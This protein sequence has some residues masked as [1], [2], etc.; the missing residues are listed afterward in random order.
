[1]N[2]TDLLQGN[3]QPLQGGAPPI[4][5][6]A[7]P[8]N[9]ASTLTP[10]TSVQV[11]APYAPTPAQ[12]A[13]QPVPQVGTGIS[14]KPQAPAT[15]VQLNS[16]FSPYIATRPSPSNPNVLEYYN[17]Q[18]GQGFSTPQDLFNFASTLGA[19][20]I[21]SFDQL[22]APVQGAQ[23]TSY[24]GP[25]Q[26]ANSQQALA[27]AAG[28]AG[29][30]PSDFQQLAQGSSILTPDQIQQI[31]AG[32]GITPSTISSVFAPP[33]Q[34]TVDFYNQAYTNAGLDQIKQQYD[35]LTQQIS[36]AQSDYNT[37]L[38]TLNENPFLS[39][40]SLTQRQGELNQQAQ[41]QI[42]NLQQQ[43][44]SLQSLYQTGLQQVAGL[45][46]NYTTDFQNIQ[47]QNAT[48][49]NFLMQQAEALA[50]AQQ[51]ANVQ[52]IYRY[53]PDYLTAAQKAQQ[54]FGSAQYGYFKYDPTTKSFTQVSGPAP[55]FQ[56]NPLDGT[57]FNTATGQGPSA[58]NGGLSTAFGSPP[59]TTGSGANLP[60]SNNNPGDL[61]N[62]STG[63]FMVYST[64]QQGWDALVSDIQA[65]ISGNN[66]HGLTPNSTLQDFANVYDPASANSSNNPAKYAQDLA[67][68]L[69]VPVTTPIGTLSNRVQ[70]FA[71]AI[72]N[73]EGYFTGST[74]PGTTGNTLIQQAAQALVDGN[75][76]PS[77]YSK[78]GATY[79]TI[80]NAANQLSMAQ[81][82]VPF[83][84]QQAETNFSNREAVRPILNNE[85]SAET[86]LDT[87]LQKSA[88]FSRSDSPTANN[89]LIETG[90]HIT[91]SPA[92][93]DYL[94]AVQDAQ[95]EIAKVLSGTGTPTDE[96][97]SE[98]ANMLNPNLGHNALVSQINTIRSLMQQKIAAY[99]NNSLGVTTASPSQQ[100]LSV[101]SSPVN[102]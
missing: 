7:N 27:Q 86:H 79:Q 29:L 50:T 36:K 41:A 99:T 35:D 81:K 67:N 49:L 31:W 63:Q 84:A 90:K 46:Q 4:Q 20:P 66:A 28:N 72:A 43:Q 11:P 33:A 83:D 37:A 42:S 5:G 45:T 56:S 73:N 40:T 58:S 64:P 89:L 34:S 24:S 48:K 61:T 53:L 21:N 10:T 51:S 101:S 96:A 2:E 32:L 68:Q 102:I 1:M 97:R 74:A 44:A 8:Q 92:V 62:P 60:Q 13:P 57:L 80:L 71:V 95:A 59:P 9:Q 38:G 98:A 15:P 17:S 12:P 54:P 26:P 77:Q 100:N 76:A 52:S 39:E 75:A 22:H 23:T 70:D 85:A 82:G 93:N 30:S 19:G 47:S 91:G 3:S 6:G 18:T 88:A 87:V 25:G 69:G 94:T 16:T 65:K 14:T 55:Q 78:R